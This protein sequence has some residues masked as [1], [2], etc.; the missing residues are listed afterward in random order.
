MLLTKNKRISGLYLLLIVIYLLQ[1]FTAA[2]N[3]TVLKKY[4]VDA[5]QIRLLTL[6]IALPYIVI[7][8]IA[9][10]G[11]LRLYTYGKFIEHEKDGAAFKKIAQGML[12]LT[13]WLPLSSLVANVS[14]QYYTNHSDA[15]ATLVRFNNYFNLCILF[16]GFWLVYKGTRLLLTTIKHSETTL[17]SLP[18]M[19]TFIALSTHFV[20]LTFQDPARQFPTHQVAVA[21]YYEPNWLLFLTL[22]IPRLLYYFIGVVAIYNIY[23]YKTKVKGS[24]YKQALNRLAQG[25]IAVV[26]VTMVLR[27]LQSLSSPLEKFSLQLLLVLI[28]VLLILIAVGYLLIAKG[29]K[30]LQQLE[31]L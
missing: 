16:I 28:Y 6:T 15:T 4:H 25:L 26:G 22:V 20:Y 8:L 10:V 2:I 9:L 30:K 13:L 19:F 23:V 5:T 14:T 24:L 31:E 18:F 17:V 11:Y 1:T 7:W 29:A 12:W 21:S 27:C 3:P